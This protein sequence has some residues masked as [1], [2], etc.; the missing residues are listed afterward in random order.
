MFD[1]P[2]IMRQAQALARHAGADQTQIATNLA[3]ADTPGYRG[4]RLEAF[5]LGDAGGR[6]GTALRTTRPGHMSGDARDA[7]FRV[8]AT[9]DAA[10]LNGNDVSIEREMVRAAEAQSRHTTAVTV[11][12]A[13]L[14]LMRSALGRGR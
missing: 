14:D 12:K 9:G 2:Q 13:S 7:P 8:V 3:N 1:M 11:Y 4:R 6:D 5:T 10:D